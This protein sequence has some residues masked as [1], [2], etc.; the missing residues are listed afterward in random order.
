MAEWRSRTGERLQSGQHL[1]RQ[2]AQGA[3]VHRAEPLAEHRRRDS[4]DGTGSVEGKKIAA[5]RK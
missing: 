1:V 3:V 4:I 2:G 5:R